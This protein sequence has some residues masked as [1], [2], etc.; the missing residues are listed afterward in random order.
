MPQLMKKV[1]LLFII[2]ISISA[3]SQKTFD[4]IKSQKLG[5]ERRI[6]IGLPESYEANPEK[7][8]LFYIY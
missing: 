6:T 7:N 8:T 3:F 5:V 1:Y 2:L 4:N